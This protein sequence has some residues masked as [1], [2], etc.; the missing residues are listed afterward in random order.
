MNVHEAQETILR[1][2]RRLAEVDD[3]QNVKVHP[4]SVG[5]AASRAA[6]REAFAVIGQVESERCAEC[7]ATPLE[8]GGFI[9]HYFHGGPPKPDQ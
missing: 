6:I 3:E 5:A 2:A 1:H 8:P 7:G 4:T 9:S